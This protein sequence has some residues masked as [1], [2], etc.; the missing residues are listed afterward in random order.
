MFSLLQPSAGPTCSTATFRTPEQ[1]NRPAL[2]RAFLV[3]ISSSKHTLLF[4]LE[5]V[6]AKSLRSLRLYEHLDCGFATFM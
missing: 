3:Y 5:T 6:N 1:P 2:Q 4:M